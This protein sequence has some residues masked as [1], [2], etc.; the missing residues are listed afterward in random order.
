LRQRQDQRY[1]VVPGLRL[2]PQLQGLLG[3]PVGLQQARGLAL[4]L[5]AARRSE[6]F[7]ALPQQELPE[8]RVVTVQRRHIGAAFD[9]EVAPV[10][11]LQQ[12]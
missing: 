10:Q 1:G 12:R 7:F 5:P 11:G 9:E 2:D 3:P 8:Q 4:Q 6:P